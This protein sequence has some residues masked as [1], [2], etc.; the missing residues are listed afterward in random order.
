M[1]GMGDEGT[2]DAR[3]AVCGA[4]INEVTEP[5]IQV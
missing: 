4:G 3:K 1:G 2:I 5:L